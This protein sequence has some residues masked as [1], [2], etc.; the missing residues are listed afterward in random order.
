M[1]TVY[2]HQL[3]HR[4]DRQAAGL[5]GSSDAGFVFDV[6]WLEPVV[7]EFEH[8]AGLPGVEFRRAAI[9]N[10]G[11]EFYDHYFLQCDDRG[12]LDFLVD[13]TLQLLALIQRWN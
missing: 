9:G 4:W 7:E 1:A 6:I 2:V 8:P 5:E 12:A 13:V 10:R 3:P 11:T